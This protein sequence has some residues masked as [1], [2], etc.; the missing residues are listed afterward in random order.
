[1]NISITIYKITDASGSIDWECVR[2]EGSVIMLSGRDKDGEIRHFESKAY[3][4]IRWA[5]EHDFTLDV[6]TKQVTI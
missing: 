2:E 5:Q 3:H 6:I 4:A 1:M